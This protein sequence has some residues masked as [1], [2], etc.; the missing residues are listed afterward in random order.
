VA[1]HPLLI[2]AASRPHPREV[3]N[4]DR[5]R[6]EQHGAIHR[7][8]VIDGLGHGPSAATA[9]ALAFDTLAAMPDADAP[10]SVRACHAALKGTRG[11]A[12]SV[13][14]ID[15]EAGR[16]TFAGLGNVEGVLVSSLRKELLMPQRGIA[17][18][19]APRIRQLEV[20]LPDSF[21]IVMCSDGIASGARRDI[22]FGPIVSAGAL[23]DEILTVWGR[24]D[25]D[26]TVVVASRQ[27]LEQSTHLET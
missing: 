13:M 11:A 8:A 14:Q 23:A 18:A 25:D 6:L 15:L 24:K 26:A 4:G 19:I 3:V 17:G 16:M 1:Q 27:P 12:L 7:L 9:A 22:R 2:G 10:S 20:S 21:I 5:V